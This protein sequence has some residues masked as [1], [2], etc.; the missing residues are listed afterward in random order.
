MMLNK[1]KP[2][3]RSAVDV[4]KYGAINFFGEKVGHEKKI[5]SNYRRCLA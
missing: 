2:A 1:C 5:G 4:D 3:G